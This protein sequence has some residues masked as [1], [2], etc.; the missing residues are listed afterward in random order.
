MILTYRTH[1]VSTS[2]V[3]C[4]RLPQATLPL[5]FFSSLPSSASGN[6]TIIFFLLAA[7][8]CL[9]QPY[10][11]IF[12]P[13]CLRVPQATVPLYFFSSLPSSASGSHTIIFFLLAAFECLRQP[14][15]Y[16]FSP[17]CLRVP[18]AAI[19][20]LNITYWY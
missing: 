2:A 5:Y 13:R 14:Y 18:Q 8:E 9:R 1:S 16:I 6:H 15:H 3:S 17:R 4:L 12:S 11:Y 19:Q 7:F 20:K 10:H